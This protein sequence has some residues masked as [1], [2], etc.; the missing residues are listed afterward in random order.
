MPHVKLALL[1]FR[2]AYVVLF[3]WAALL[4]AASALALQLPG[5]LR[6]HGLEIPDGNYREAHRLLAKEFRIPEEPVIV[7]VE[8]TGSSSPAAIEQFVHE[9]ANRIRT[10]GGVERVSGPVLA[11][12]GLA[13]Y[14]AVTIAVQ[15]SGQER[16]IAELR[17][18]LPAS[19]A[20]T[21]GLAG[22]PVVQADVNAA[23]RRDLLRAEL[24][25]LPVAFV[26][27]R[28]AFGSWTAALLPIALGVSAVTG[29]MGI[30]SAWS[31]RIPWSVFV[32]SVIP[33]TGLAIGLDF[34]L[35]LVARF[36]EELRLTPSAEAAAKTAMRTAGCAVIVSS[37]CVLLGLGGIAA[38]PLPM[39]STV[40]L[41]AMLTVTLALLLSFTLLPALLAVAAP[42]LQSLPAPSARRRT[43]LTGRWCDAV[44]RRPVA[45]A[46]F[47]ALLLS[48][49]LLPLGGMKLAVPG[50]DSLPASYESRRTAEAFA[51]AGFEPPVS[52]R[53][54]IVAEAA[55]GSPL[56]LHSRPWSPG[57]AEAA[58]AL[59]VRLQNDPLV[60]DVSSAASAAALPAER[61]RELL[62]QPGQAVRYAPGTAGYIQHKYT[63]LS[64]TLAAEPSSTEAREWVDRL[65]TETKSAAFFTS[66]SDSFVTSLN[67]PIRLYVGGEA[68][69]ERELFAVLA[70]RLPL[71]AG[72]IAAANLLMLLAAFR[73][74]IIA[75]KTVLMHLAGLGAAF[76]IVTLVCQD[77]RFGLEPTNI[78]IMIPVFIF[79][80][81]FG[82][83]MDYGVFL[84]ARISEA[85]RR[86]GSNAAAIR[87]GVEATGPLIT[88]AAAIMIAVTIPFAAADVA[89]V[90]QLGIGIAAAIALDA[91]VVRL[92]LVPALMQLLGRCNWWPGRT[93]A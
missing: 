34:A 40:A 53:I 27:L 67:S 9:A 65:L 82:I 25:G 17:N 47:A 74:A 60:L 19:T 86:T 18:R 68:A 6:G 29:A 13:A 46:V 30:A 11:K 39:F 64:V 77:G 44:L 48:F 55:G 72:F 2:H 38:L 66:M 89:G 93:G 88:A 80:L 15:P 37:A 52:T 71:A 12:S 73:A 26:I 20:F 70:N 61:L 69:Y 28:I 1:C 22:K 78:A 59:A 4:T 62:L 41:A 57:Q 58:A 10:V 51:R 79:G 54:W 23:A 56:K 85:Y 81:V 91:T 5:S 8:P 45:A 36:R 43:S 87:E 33:M 63:L 14:A 83:S 76:G 21:A 3:L 75:V 49:F 50:P 92:L 24:I 31:G 90:R 84:L 42:L 35:I 7:Y 32:L 16:L